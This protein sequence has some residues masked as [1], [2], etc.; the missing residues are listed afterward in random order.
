MLLKFKVADTFDYIEA[1]KEKSF[2][3]DIDPCDD[4]ENV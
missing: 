4:I 2:S 1:F 3:I